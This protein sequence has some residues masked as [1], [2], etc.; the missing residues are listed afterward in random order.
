MSLLY[1]ISYRFQFN[2]LIQ[3]RRVHWELFSRT[4]PT[5]LD[6][7]FS[8]SFLTIACSQRPQSFYGWTSYR[9]YSAPNSAQHP[10]LPD[11][12]HVDSPS[13]HTI[14][15]IQDMVVPVSSAL[16]ERGGSHLFSM[17]IW[18]GSCYF[19]VE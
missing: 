9:M 3:K 15:E 7:R 13:S 10:P 4:G 11:H 19:T 16:E 6:F 1:L 2:S 8:S 12:S 5:H 17:R 18:G 14:L